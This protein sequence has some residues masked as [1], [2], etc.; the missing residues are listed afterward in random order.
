L[1][2]LCLGLHWHLLFTSPEK[3]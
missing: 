1:Q 3:E 2:C